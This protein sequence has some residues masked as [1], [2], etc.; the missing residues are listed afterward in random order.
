MDHIKLCLFASGLLSFSS[1]TLAGGTGAIPSAAM[2]QTGYF[3][4]LGGSYNQMRVKSNTW[5]IMNATS[6][7]PPNGIFS[8]TT[9]G[10]Y[11]SMQTFSPQGQVGYFQNFKGSNWLWGI[12]L[13][14]QYSKAEAKAKGSTINLINPSANTTD[15]ISMDIQTKV[16]SALVLPV[17]IGHSFTNSFIYLGVG[18]SLLRTQDTVYGSSDTHSGYY[19]GTLEKF[20]AT[21]WRWGGAIQAGMAYYFNPSWFFKLNYTYAAIGKY[22]MNNSISFSPEG[23]EGLNAGTVTFNTR[24]RLTTQDVAVSIN[25]VFSL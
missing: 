10:H 1:L 18:P 23:N 19:I 20:S 12:E 11:D 14:Y 13:L 24:Q 9:N 25:K 7:I 16:N 21:H 22:N 15:E 17:F 6:G 5:G 3:F 2:N 4:G 8:G